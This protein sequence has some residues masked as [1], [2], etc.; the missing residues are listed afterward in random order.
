MKLSSIIEPGDRQQP[1][2][3]RVQ[4]RERHVRRADHQRDH[5]VAE[6]GEGRDHEQ[7]DHQRGVH[8][9]Q[10]VEGLVVD[11]LHAGPRELGA[12]QHRH[13]PAGDEEED[14]RDQVLDADHLVVGVRAEVVLPRPAAV[15]RVVLRDRRRAARVPEPV[16]ERAEAGEEADRR[17][18]QRGDHGDHRPAEERLPARPGAEDQDDPAADPPEQ[19]RHPRGP[20]PA[21]LQEVVAR[22]LRRVRC[23]HG[24]V[25][26]GDG[27]R[28]CPPP[29]LEATRK[30][31]R[32]SS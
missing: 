29:L 12:E 21:R 23:S 6:A 13:H 4:P 14:R 3:Q 2:R 1:V 16:V 24:G 19:A 20:D 26:L 30:V 25:R 15:R 9:D 17:G 8:R 7:E 11:E 32:A 22:G 28:H 5:V 18:G 27:G 31:T 10:A